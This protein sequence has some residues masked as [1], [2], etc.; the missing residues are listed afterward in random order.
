VASQV[1]LSSIELVSDSHRLFMDL[2]VTNA[3]FVSRRRQ[4]VLFIVQ[5]ILTENQNL[6]SVTARVPCAVLKATH[7]LC[8]P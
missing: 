7:R 2:C 6:V 4:M 5:F 1:V 3:S 8:F